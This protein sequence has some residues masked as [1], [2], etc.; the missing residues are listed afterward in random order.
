MRSQDHEIAL[1]FLSNCSEIAIMLNQFNESDCE[2]LVDQ[3]KHLVN[4]KIFELTG[5]YKPNTAKVKRKPKP[6]NLNL[7]MLVLESLMEDYIKQL[8]TSVDS[9]SSSFACENGERLRAQI[10]KQMEFSVA[11]LKSA[12]D[13]IRELHIIQEERW[14]R[15]ATRIVSV[16]AIIISTIA[17][18]V[19]FIDK[20]F[21]PLDA[22]Q[23]IVLVDENGKPIKFHSLYNIKPQQN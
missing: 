14:S 9:Y 7:Q 12:T 15:Q 13:L 5:H 19:P 18:I 10:T 1:G 2:D 3:Y 6:I 22:M 4:T 21:F 23:H 11:D 20:R 16:F 17:I 8:N